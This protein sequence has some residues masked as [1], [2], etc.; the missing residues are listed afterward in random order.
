MDT[1]KL[2]G[3]KTNMIAHRGVSKLERENTCASFI[4]AGNRSYY[5]IETDILVT[6]D[7][8]FVAMHDDTAERVTLGACKAN[9]TRSTL[10]EVQSIRL[11]DLDG[12]F[13]RSDIRIPTLADYVSICKKYGKVCILEVKNIFK[14]DDLARMIGEIRKLEY[15]ENVIF[16]SIEYENCVNLREMMPDAQ[17]QYLTGQRMDDTVLDMI[18]SIGIDAGIDIDYSNPARNKERIDLLHR[19]GIK[20]NVCVCDDP[21]L[22]RDIIDMGADYLT[23]NILE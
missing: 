21:E 13:A 19:H 7:G 8:N 11:P 4:A 12:S 2:K 22:A 14:K 18:T 9:I 15:L 5:G 17:I 1:I 16:I 20:V 3:K 23:T 10:E 6:G